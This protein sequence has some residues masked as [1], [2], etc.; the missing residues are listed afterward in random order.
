MNLLARAGNYL[1]G[2][3]LVL[4]LVIIGVWSER[5]GPG[6]AF[7]GNMAVAAATTVTALLAV[8]VFVERAMAVFNA[9]LFGDQHRQAEAKLLGS[10]PAEGVQEMQNVMSKKE[11][12]RLLGSFIAGAF[13][14]AAGVRTLAGLLIVPAQNPPANPFFL[15]VDVVLTAGLIAGG[16]NGLAFL[17]QVIKDMMAPPDEAAPPGGGIAPGIQTEAPTPSGTPAAAVSSRYFRARM[18]TG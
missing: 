2:A 14:S 12:V 5:L 11:R 18:T 3:A 4:A 8:T 17:L 10:N 15:P 9:I 16:S 13:I 1:L 6:Y 7:Q